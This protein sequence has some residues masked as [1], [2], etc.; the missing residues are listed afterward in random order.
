MIYVGANDGMLHAFDAADD[1]SR[2]LHRRTQLQTA[3][4]IKLGLQDI[5]I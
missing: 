3:D 5:C 1:D 2:R 4:V